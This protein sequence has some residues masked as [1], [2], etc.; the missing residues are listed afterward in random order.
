MLHL[1]NLPN[2]ADDILDRL[3]GDDVLL[4]QK[5]VCCVKKGHA[6]NLKLLNLIENACSIYVLEDYLDVFGIKKTDVLAGIH[7]IDYSGF[8]SL[9]VKNSV[10]VTWSG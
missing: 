8:V 9:T 1:L 10:I 2:L 6:D 3:A 4:Q 7:I 5:L